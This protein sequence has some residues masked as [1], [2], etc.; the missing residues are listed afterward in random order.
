MRNVIEPTAFVELF[1]KYPPQDFLVKTEPFGIP[2]FT[3]NLDLLTTMDEALSARIR[4]LPFYRYWGRFL[5]LSS[6]F[7]GTT[8]TEHCPLPKNVSAK[9]FMEALHVAYADSQALFIV[10]DLPNNSPLVSDEDNAYADELA[11]IADSM[12]YIVV[13]GEAL[14]YNNVDFSS[15]DEYLARLSS[16]RRKNLRRKLRSREMLGVDVLPLGDPF[17]DD[18]SVADELYALFKQVYDNSLIHFDLLTKDY[19]TALVRSKDISGV[20]F[21]YVQGERTVGYNICLTH[22]NMLID[23]TI[24]MDYALSRA[25]NLYHISWMENLRYARTHGYTCYVSG[26][27]AIEAKASLGASFTMTRHLVWVRNPVLRH[28]LRLCRGLFE[29]DSKTLKKVF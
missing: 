16:A 5:R 7:C 1:R 19:L 2:I 8:T 20:V 17:F 11:R 18:D 29:S 9:A 25:V 12:G 23:K 10:K 24:A 6:S 14:A 3:M 26:C 13:E 15:E 21:R 28:L 27:T 22:G 4:R